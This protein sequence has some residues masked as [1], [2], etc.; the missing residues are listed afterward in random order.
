[1][2][3]DLSRVFSQY[4]FNECPKLFCAAEFDPRVNFATSPVLPLMATTQ[5]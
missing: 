1:M 4:F 3:A 2:R 5:S